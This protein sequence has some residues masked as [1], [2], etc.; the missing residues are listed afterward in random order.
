MIIRV[1]VMYAS[2]RD[3]VGNLIL[4]IINLCLTTLFGWVGIIFFSQLSNGK[5]LGNQ[6]AKCKGSDFRVIMY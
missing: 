3:G 6:Q 1:Y 4:L 2:K 5:E